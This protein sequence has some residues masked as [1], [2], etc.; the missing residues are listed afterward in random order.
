MMRRRYRL[1]QKVLSPGSGNFCLLSDT[2]ITYVVEHL[3][4][5]GIEVVEGPSEKIGATGR[6]LSVY[7]RDP[8]LN[9]IEVSNIL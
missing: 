3:R 9:L 5:N 8:D 4:L 1:S 6:I 2:P 7:F